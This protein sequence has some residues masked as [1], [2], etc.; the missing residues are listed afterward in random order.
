[1]PVHPIE[2]RSRPLGRATRRGLIAKTRLALQP[3]YPSR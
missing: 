3:P 2:R 1:M